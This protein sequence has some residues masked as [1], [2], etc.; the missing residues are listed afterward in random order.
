ME[1]SNNLF[2]AKT[3][4]SK[5]TA[6]G[7]GLKKL[8]MI[9]VVFPAH[10]EI[11]A[12]TSKNI[13]IPISEKLQG[14]AVII[15]DYLVSSVDEICSETMNITLQGLRNNFTTDLTFTRYLFG[16]WIPFYPYPVTNEDLEILVKNLSATDIHLWIYFKGIIVNNEDV[17]RAMKLLLPLEAL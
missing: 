6:N 8:K 11:L 17:D 3:K 1:R 15:T 12:N 7:S 10:D 13:N 9:N 4:E 14:K 2:M 5:D 16:T